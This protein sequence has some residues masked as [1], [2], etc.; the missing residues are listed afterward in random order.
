MQLQCITNA[1]VVQENE[2]RAR[3]VALGA[4]LLQV[5]S[6]RESRPNW[7]AA[8]GLNYDLGSY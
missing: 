1:G 5:E 2:N 6:S 3:K 7:S 4:I 8:P